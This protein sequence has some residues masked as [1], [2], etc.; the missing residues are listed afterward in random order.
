MG[1]SDE[2]RRMWDYY[3]SYSEGGFR[4]GTVDVGFYGFQRGAGNKGWREAEAS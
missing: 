4:G 2:F 3:L 1:F